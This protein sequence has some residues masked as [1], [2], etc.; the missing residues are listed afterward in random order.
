MVAGCDV[1]GLMGRG[2]KYTVPV[3]PHGSSSE[4]GIF[5]ATP[6]RR[7]VTVDVFGAVATDDGGGGPKKAVMLVACDPV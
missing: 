6:Y 7:N 4:V 2:T 1:G 3:P 5:L